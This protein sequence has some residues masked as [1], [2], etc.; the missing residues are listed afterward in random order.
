MS[1]RH[2]LK[3]FSILIL[4]PNLRI[5]FAIAAFHECKISSDVKIAVDDELKQSITVHDTILELIPVISKTF[6]L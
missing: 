4:C 1:P 3:S 5:R 2:S 6:M